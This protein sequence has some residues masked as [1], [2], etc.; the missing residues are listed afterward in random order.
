MIGRKMHPGGP[1]LA[2]PLRE[3]PGSLVP[4]YSAFLPNALMLN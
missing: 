4:P 2:D 1:A 3:Y